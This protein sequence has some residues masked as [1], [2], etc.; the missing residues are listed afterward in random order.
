MPCD[1]FDLKFG[2][3]PP[4]S[5]VY[6]PVYALPVAQLCVLAAQLIACVVVLACI[7][8]WFVVRATGRANE[9]SHELDVVKVL[10]VSIAACV[11]TTLLYVSGVGP[12]D[13]FTRC[14]EFLHQMSIS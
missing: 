11:S 4:R 8:P 2:P 13:T 14:C 12:T 7:Q 10:A 1:N 3:A 5:A 6:A 9:S